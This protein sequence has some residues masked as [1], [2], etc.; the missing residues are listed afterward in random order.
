MK[1]EK[2]Y[3]PL[4]YIKCELIKEFIKGMDQNSAGFMCLK[5]KFPRISDC[6]IKEGVFVGP[7]IRELVQEIKFEDQLS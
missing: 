4:L 3:L 1:P 5:I 6:K 7:Q 2:V